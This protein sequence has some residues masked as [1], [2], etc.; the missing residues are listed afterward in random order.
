MGYIIGVV[1]DHPLFREGLK[2]ILLRNSDVA[3]VLTFCDGEDVIK[4]L[5]EDGKVDVFFMDIIMPICDGLYTTEYIKKHYPEIK[6]L[7]LSSIDRVEFVEKM[8]AAGADGYLLKECNLK[9]ITE[10]LI[11]V[12]SDSNYFSPKIIVALSESTKLRLQTKPEDSIIVGLSH[13]ELE[14]FKN[15]CN[16]YSRREIAGMLYISE[17]TVDKHKENIFKKTGCKSL[18]QLVVTAIKQGVLKLEEL[19]NAL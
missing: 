12:L 9:D 17:K 19:E 15:L 4:F 13:R 14:V 10:A 11:A 8:I 6:V 1:D 3:E 5:K 18:I 7:G 2:A 16:G